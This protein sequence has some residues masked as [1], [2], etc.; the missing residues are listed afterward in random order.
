MKLKKLILF[1]LVLFCG[2]TVMVACERNAEC[3]LDAAN[4]TEKDAKK[5]KVSPISVTS[6]TH[7]L[8]K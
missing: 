7:T 4:T 2:L 1:Q 5:I 3:K 8:I 6:T